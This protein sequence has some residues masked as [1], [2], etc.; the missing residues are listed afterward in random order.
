LGTLEL[1]QVRSQRREPEG[2][3]EER[4]VDTASEQGVYLLT[5]DGATAPTEAR[6]RVVVVTRS[7]RKKHVRARI[8]SLPLNFGRGGAGRV[9]P[10]ASLGRPDAPQPTAEAAPS[11]RTPL[12]VAALLGLAALLALVWVLGG[13]LDLMGRLLTTAPPEAPAP[14]EAPVDVPPEPPAPTPAPVIAP[15]PVSAKRK[16]RD[17]SAP[18]VTDVEPIQV[19]V[20]RVEKRPSVGAVLVHGEVD[21]IGAPARTNI[22]LRTVLIEEEEGSMVAQRLTWCCQTLTDADADAAATDPLH[23]HFGAVVSDVVGP[24][25]T[26]GFSVL[27]TLLDEYELEGALS[28]E[29]GILSSAPAADPP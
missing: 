17:A 5:R 3:R 11:R 26:R 15:K 23:P 1:E 8:V 9:A 18:L 13:G 16:R 12:L 10:P 20:L 4:G 29:A 2:V 22:R 21:N 27:F 14:R 25:R 7:P 19:R 28:A 6:R 24:G